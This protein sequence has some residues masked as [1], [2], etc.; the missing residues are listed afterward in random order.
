M[1][2]SG[3][4]APAKPPITAPGPEVSALEQA[5]D[6]ELGPEDT[7]VDKKEASD[8]GNDKKLAKA[9]LEM[10]HEAAV[11]QKKES[12]AMKAELLVATGSLNVQAFREQVEGVR[13]MKT[14]NGSLGHA[15]T[16][17]TPRAC[18]FVSSK[19]QR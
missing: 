16:D 3:S 12:M 13:S 14:A 11:F 1:V 2:L 10:H 4:V 8:Q 9:V 17:G 7:V 19:M 18:S 15:E 5:L 6:V